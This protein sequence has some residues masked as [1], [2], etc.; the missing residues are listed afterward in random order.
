LFF[1]SSFLLLAPKKQFL[2]KDKRLVKGRDPSLWTG[3]GVCVVGARQGANYKHLCLGLTSSVMK[4][5]SE[6]LSPGKLQPKRAF[7]QDPRASAGS[8]RVEAGLLVEPD[9]CLPRAHRSSLWAVA[10]EEGKEQAGVKALDL[11]VNCFAGT[12]RGSGQRVGLYRSGERACR[13]RFPARPPTLR[14]AG[15]ANLSPSWDFN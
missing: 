13:H 8:T 15:H 9:S 2:L 7:L 1:Q 4:E 3:R 11:G 12:G 5:A 10:W 14:P 6:H